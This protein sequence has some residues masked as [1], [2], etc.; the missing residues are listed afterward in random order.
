[1]AL[2]GCRVLLL[3][4]DKLAGGVNV[5]SPRSTDAALRA[6]VKQAG[7]EGFSINGEPPIEANRLTHVVAGSLQAFVRLAPSLHRRYVVE[8]PPGCPVLVSHQWL[9]TA[10]EETRRPAERSFAVPERAPTPSDRACEVSFAAPERAP[11]PSDRAC[12]VFSSSAA[13]SGG[14]AGGGSGGAA[15]SA[16]TSPSGDAW[17]CPTC[18]CKNNAAACTACGTR[19]LHHQNAQPVIELLSDDDDEELSGRP[20][21]CASWQL[22][23]EGHRAAAAAA[24]APESDEALALRLARSDEAAA[25]NDA[26]V[27]LARRLQS[28]DDAGGARR[29]KLKR[30]RSRTAVSTPPPP[31]PRRV[32]SGASFMLNKLA[33]REPEGTARPPEIDV[34]DIIWDA[35][36]LEAAIFTSYGTNYEQLL[37]LLDAMPEKRQVIVCDTYDHLAAR[38]AV[39]PP[40]GN[41]GRHPDDDDFSANEE[42]TVVHPCMDTTYRSSG[43][44][45]AKSRQRGERGTMHPKLILLLFPDFLRISISSANIGSYEN[46]INQAYWIHDVPRQAKRGASSQASQGSSFQVELLDFVKKILMVDPSRGIPRDG[47]AEDRMFHVWGD[48]LDGLDKATE[49]LWNVPSGV[50]LVASIP[51]TYITQEDRNRYGHMRIRALLAEHLHP[52]HGEDLVPKRV[53]LQV[54]SLGSLGAFGKR[55]VESFI[56]SV[57]TD[58]ASTAIE[59]AQDAAVLQQHKREIEQVRDGKRVRLELRGLNGYQRRKCHAIA[60]DFGL[61]HDSR[62]TGANRHLHIFRS[63]HESLMKF[64]NGTQSAQKCRSDDAVSPAA[65]PA[66]SPQPQPAVDWRSLKASSTGPI[67]GVSRPKADLRLVWPTFDTVARCVLSVGGGDER[68]STPG[69]LQ[70]RAESAAGMTTGEDWNLDS[71]PRPLFCDHLPPWV[72]S[73]RNLPLLVMSRPVSDRSLVVTAT[74][75]V[76]APSLED[77]R[78]DNHRRWRR[79]PCAAGGG[80][81]RALSVGL[82]RLAQLLDGGVGCQRRG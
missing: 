64:S 24:A 25:G 63:P 13:A 62:G 66:G 73:L 40:T 46:K 50:H 31:G 55:F 72:S 58:S 34:P 80:T 39:H 10:L 6:R 30:R 14:A 69:Q 68:S 28:E 71:Y 16:A 57:G 4:D 51:G 74:P 1:M 38:A 9:T 32:F 53:E 17:V 26:S 20:E 3:R 19:R 52:T 36:K 49:L 21:G 48:L 59:S 11:T 18:T 82:R 42:F 12:E 56:K 5:S 8:A 29:Q 65:S 77:R 44:A 47:T 45:S 70:A 79:R 15:A 23:A 60:E 27:R 43:T 81:S 67:G 78:S 76:H 54:S 75:A 33:G 22:Q 41:P 2:A 7:A 35:S 61:E 37:A